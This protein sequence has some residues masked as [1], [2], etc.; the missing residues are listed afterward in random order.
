MASMSDKTAA[1]AATFKRETSPATWDQA[2]A[3]LPYA[4]ALQSWAWGQFKARWGWRSDAADD[5]GG[6]Q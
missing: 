4:H 3:R 6:R 2:L 1:R 5:V